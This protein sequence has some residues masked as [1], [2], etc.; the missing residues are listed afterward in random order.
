MHLISALL[1][2]IC[3]G[4][5]I[6][7]KSNTTLG[8]KVI[9]R[10]DDT[11]YN[12]IL[13]IDGTTQGFTNI[14]ALVIQDGFEV[15][16]EY[17]TPMVHKSY[18]Y[19]LNGDCTRHTIPVPHALRSFLL[20][21]ITF[22]NKRQNITVEKGHVLDAQLHNEYCIN[23]NQ[24]TTVRLEDGTI[25]VLCGK[26]NQLPHLVVS[27]KFIITLTNESFASYKHLLNKAKTVCDNMPDLYEKY[28]RTIPSNQEPWF[29]N[30]ERSCQHDAIRH[31][32]NCN[33]M[34][35]NAFI[36]QPRKRCVFLHGVGQFLVQKGP[37]TNE[38]E[39]Y[40]GKVHQFT[41]QC[42]ERW[43][44]REETKNKGWNDAGLQRA[45]CDIALGHNSDD[46]IV[47]DTVLFVHSMGNLV[48]SA[49]IKNGLCDIDT[50]TTSWYQIMGPFGGSKAALTLES[51]CEGAE[52]G[53]WPIGKAKLYRFVA[54]K[55]G[56]CVPGTKHCYPAYL[57][58][59]P[60][61]MTQITQEYIDSLYQIANKRIKGSMCGT[62]PVGV[63][64]LYSIA[65]KTLSV[66]VDYG[67][68][69]DGLVPIS[70]CIRTSDG[71]NFT[72]HYSSSWYKAKVN[73]ADGTCRNSDSYFGDS[74]SPCSYYKNKL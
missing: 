44:I 71:R 53:Q 38:F 1:L 12:G 65:L 15:L 51:V 28:Q 55:G 40:W 59:S 57:T 14:H 10:L 68:D 66:V 52:S 46:M 69:S 61:Y 73:H 25:V 34:R 9:S 54:D 35:A 56:Y 49:A 64:S 42:S 58:M 11:K 24:M 4:A 33:M 18:M 5:S 7:F 36:D 74:S 27:E 48:L 63:T 29:I 13:S 60:G 43:F 50:N 45:Y 2:L 32:S 21:P 72:S 16:Y 70:S 19:V 31:D 26:H 41:P 8:F 22:Y 47:R 20:N 37:V 39:E 17:E 3:I 30:Y 6:Q 23:S 62:S 67:E